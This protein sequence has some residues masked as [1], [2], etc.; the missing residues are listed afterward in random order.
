MIFEEW[1]FYDNL[2]TFILLCDIRL[3]RLDIRSCLPW[4]NRRESHQPWILFLNGPFCPILGVGMIAMISTNTT[5]THTEIQHIHFLIIFNV[6]SIV[7]T[8]IEYFGGWIY[9]QIFHARWWDYRDMP[10][11]INGYVC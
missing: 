1:S 3:L 9:D 8:L 2:S 5:V 7:C 4:R 10:F 6:G 11:N